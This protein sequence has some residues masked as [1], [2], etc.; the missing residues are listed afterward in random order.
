MAREQN[1]N[2]VE[3]ANKSGEIGEWNWGNVEMC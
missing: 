2:L 1:T 3:I